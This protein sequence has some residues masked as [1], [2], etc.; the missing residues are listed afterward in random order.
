MGLVDGWVASHPSF[1]PHVRCSLPQPNMY[2]QQQAAAE[3]AAR[4][5]RETAA[6]VQQEEGDAALLASAEAGKATEASALAA[7][8]RARGERMGV[9]V[10]W[11][12][13]REG[14]VG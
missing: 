2:T 7:S 3:A 1:A 13:G 10:W 5:E 9:F 11:G 14:L 4:G 12:D 8:E 6:L